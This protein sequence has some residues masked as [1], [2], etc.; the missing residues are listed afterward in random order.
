MRKL[1]SGAFSASFLIAFIPLY[2]GIQHD[3]MGEFCKNG[4]LDSCSFD[5]FHALGI[6]GS[7]FAVVFL[8]L[9]GVLFIARLC[10]VGF[11]VVT[12]K[13]GGR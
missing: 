1:I 12:D 8:S 6:W 5:Y 9:T 7:W 4:S 13:S 10:I 11:K 2:V 3:A